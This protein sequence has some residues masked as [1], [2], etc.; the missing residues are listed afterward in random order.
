M[1]DHV[2]RVVGPE[3][4]VRPLEGGF[5]SEPSDLSSTD[6]DVFALVAATVRETFGDIPVV[7]WI[8]M[9]ATDSR[10]FASI[11]GAVYRFAPF[12]ATPEDMTRIHG[13]GERL[14]VADAEQ[15]VEFYR[16]LITAA[17]GKDRPA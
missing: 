1:I 5:T 6:S 15:V 8:L 16:R 11:A 3:I 9:G 2:R 12:R 14:R 10:H 7:P 13:T 17:V 4:T